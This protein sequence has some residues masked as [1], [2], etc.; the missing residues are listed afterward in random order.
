LNDR[1]PFAQWA[2]INRTEKFICIEP[3]SGYRMTIREDDAFRIYLEPDAGEN[4]IGEAVLTALDRSRFIYPLDD[5]E[6]FRFERAKKNQRIW[7]N[8]VMKKYK[9]KTKRDLYKNSDYC[10]VER[11]EG[12][13]EIKP[14]IRDTKPGFIRDVPKEK[15]VTIPTT[16][17]PSLVGAAAKLALS[18][19]E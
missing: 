9:Y 1:L 11:S 10:R 18:R 13:I 4:A 16:D 5:R 7:E 2:T 17:D 12:V 15:I 3:M 14:H 19:C 6:F 8:E